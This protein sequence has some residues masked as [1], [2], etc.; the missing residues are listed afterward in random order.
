MGKA[1]TSESV[2]IE[3]TTFYRTQVMFGQEI[4]AKVSIEP[5]NLI[6]PSKGQKFCG[7]KEKAEGNDG[8]ITAI[9][10]NDAA[11]T[12]LP[13]PVCCFVRAIPRKVVA[14]L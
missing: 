14:L 10:W 8:Q 12:F 9:R 4:K 7:N 11:I 2:L 5:K 6:Q 1:S 3:T 13:R